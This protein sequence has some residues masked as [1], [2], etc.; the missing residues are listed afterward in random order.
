MMR[1]GI[2]ISGSGCEVKAPPNGLKRY[3][4]WLGRGIPTGRAA[5]VLNEWNLPEPVSGGEW[6]LD[7][8]FNAAQEILRDPSLKHVFRATINKGVKVVKWPD[9]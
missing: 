7:S 8:K 2:E 5:Y 1:K 4:E 9:E 6:A 3:L